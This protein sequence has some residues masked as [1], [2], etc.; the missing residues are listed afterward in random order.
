M[1]LWRRNLLVGFGF[2]FIAA[3]AALLGLAVLLRGGA[4]IVAIV[5][6]SGMFGLGLLG[7]VSTLRNLVYKT[8]SVDHRGLTLQFAFGDRYLRWDEVA[9]YRPIAQWWWLTRL[10]PYVWVIL[11]YKKEQERPQVR[12]AVVTFPIL[13]AAPIAPEALATELDMYV[14][15]KGRP[16]ARLAGSRPDGR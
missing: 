3:V 9:W 7:G 14:P 1:I 2:L 16:S 13:S 4:P 12:K 5:V 15:E 11:A 6:L 10:G 8:T